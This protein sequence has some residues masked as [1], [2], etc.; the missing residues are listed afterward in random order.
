MATKITSGSIFSAGAVV[1]GVDADAPPA[2]PAP[3]P[4]PEPVPGTS[5]LL[6]SSNGTILDASQSVESISVYGDT[7]VADSS[8]Y[9][10]G[11][12]IAFDGNGDHLD[13]SGSSSL[14]FGSADFTIE[15]WLNINSVGLYAITDPRTSGS[16]LSPLIWTKSTGELY[17]YTAGG[18]R[19][20]GSTQ[21]N[22][23]TWYHVALAKYNGTTTLYLNGSSEGS[24]SDS[25]TYEQPTNF[26]IGRRYIPNDSNNSFDLDGKISD[27]RVVKGTAVYT[28][29]F[30][31]PSAP[32]AVPS[33]E[34]EPAPAPEP[35][36]SASWVVVGA[37]GDDDN[38]TD[39]GSVYVY[40]ANDL[41]VQPTKLTAYDG[42]EIDQFGYSVAANSD[43][44]V[45]GSWR[46]DDN[47]GNSGSVYVYD[48]ND[49]SA[50]P[51]KLVP[52]NVTAGARLGNSVAATANKIVAGAH[53]EDT[54]RGSVYVFDANDLTAQPTKLTAFDGADYDR[55]GDS[56]AATSDKIVVG[57]SR[58][59]DNGTQSGSVYVFDANDLTA[60][61]TKLTAFD[62]APSD[63]FGLS[64]AA[65]AD[66]IVVGAYFD[67]D[68]GSNSGSVYVY[69][70]NDLSAT[71]TKLTAFDGAGS[72]YFGWS[73]AATADKIVVGAY[74]DDD[75]GLI[76]SGSVYVFDANDLSAQPTKL[77]AY[78]GAPDDR[79]GY[80]VA[81]MGD[82]IVV[83]AYY[84]DDDG[85]NSGSVYVFDAN[86]L[87]AQPTK[88]TAFDGDVY[89]YFGRSVAIG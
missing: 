8:P 3:E 4:A 29:N 20:V 46:D 65:T 7:T 50:Q 25:Y 49:L 79:F 5:L 41:S 60:Q 69:D 22:V 12:S 75:N 84:D 56:V 10:T 88:L 48:A 18:D 68:D 36:P 37:I 14:E 81:V 35:A 45:V 9:G 70:A 30:T 63:Y 55:F 83:N 57:S 34:P 76:N 52:F 16:S 73:V 77:T 6:S 23:N 44:I 31:V 51:T 64:V 32:L 82:K 54:Q 42:Y 11:Q 13:V 43:K 74:Y 72:D 86:D 24:F 17:Y 33:P 78:D 62:G 59:D 15:L 26:R 58:D 21:L 19:I 40:D 71:P 85:E 53:L 47:G 27:L 80:S 67:D 1:T 87:S 38:G 39:S 61:P 66:K 2:V 28:E 89:D